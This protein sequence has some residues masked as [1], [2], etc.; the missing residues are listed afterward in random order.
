MR[1]ATYAMVGGDVIHNFDGVGD[2]IRK[3]KVEKRNEMLNCGIGICKLCRILDCKKDC[4]Y[5]WL[6]SNC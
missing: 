4:I 6:Y 2:Y 5:N 3:P 1:S